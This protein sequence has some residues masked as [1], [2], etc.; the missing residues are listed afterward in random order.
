MNRAE[1][2]RDEIEGGWEVRQSNTE[3][4]V[5]VRDEDRRRKN[6]VRRP[7]SGAKKG[8]DSNKTAQTVG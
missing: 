6:G 4:E 7:K 1:K 3:D 2:E 8:E 5:S